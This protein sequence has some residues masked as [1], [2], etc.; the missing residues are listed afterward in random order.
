MSENLDGLLEVEL[1]IH[2]RTGI[3]L[4]PVECDLLLLLSQER[5]LR[6]TIRQ[7]TVRKTRERHGTRPLNEK[8]IHPVRNRAG[9]DLEDA[10]GKQPF[11]AEAMDCAA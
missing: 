10:E 7:V 8:K 6:R 11:N 4:R 9:L 5:R 2:R 3:N 1:F